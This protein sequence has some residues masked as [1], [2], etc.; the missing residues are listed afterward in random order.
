MKKRI[1]RNHED[2]LAAI[3][4]S[5]SLADSPLGSAQARELAMIRDAIKLYEDSIQ[6]MRGAAKKAAAEPDEGVAGISGSE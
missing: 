5:E 6:A 2:L 3:R 4:R 1:I